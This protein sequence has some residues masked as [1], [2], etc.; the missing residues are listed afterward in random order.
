[1]HT[2]AAEA[3]LA[4]TWQGTQKFDHVCNVWIGPMQCS[5]AGE[6][7]SLHFRATTHAEHYCC[8]QLL[9]SPAAIAA[10]AAATCYH[11]GRHSVLTRSTS[12]YMHLQYY[13]YMLRTV[14][15]TQRKYIYALH[16]NILHAP[17]VLFCANIQA[18]DSPQRNT[19]KHNDKLPPTAPTIPQANNYTR[20]DNKDDEATYQP[21]STHP[22][23]PGAHPTDG[24]RSP[25]HNPTPPIR[26]TAAD[27]T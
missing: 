19:I 2:T 6:Q 10:I 21:T 20:K 25:V 4:I 13:I 7:K 22:P 1:M 5:Q 17:F 23:G 9:P 12:A 14:C 11:Q 15:C 16:T 18:F 24:Q 3:P 26:G 27:D 8:H